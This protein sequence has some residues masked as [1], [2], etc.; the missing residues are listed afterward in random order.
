MDVFRSKSALPNEYHD[1]LYHNIGDKLDFSNS[2][3]IL[4]SDETRFKSSASEDYAYNK[5]Y[6]NPGWHFFKNVESSDTYAADVKATFEIN[7]LKDSKRYMNLFIL[8]NKNREYTK[9]MAPLTFEAPKPYDQMPTP[10]LDIRQKGEAW[11]NPFA[12]IYEP[13]LDKNSKNGIQLVTKLEDK[14]IFKGFKVVSIIDN[15]EIVQYLINQERDGIYENKEL[16]LYFKG[17]F[18]IITLD[19]KQELQ[20]VYIGEGDVLRLKKVEIQSKNAQ[21]IAANI[22]FTNGVPV[23]ISSENT[24]L[25]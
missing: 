15:K 20:N 2:D 3:L 17:A 21:K 25:K 16:G 13:T 19:K 18:A 23:V 12:V 9:V 5:K 10:T 4:K 14:G 1:Y 22:D 11:S 6:R 8:G 24:I 7:K